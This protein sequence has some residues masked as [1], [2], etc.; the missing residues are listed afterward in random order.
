M[1]NELCSCTIQ[2][3]TLGLSNKEQ[4]VLLIKV[5]N[6]KKWNFVKGVKNRPRA[7][8][9]IPNVFHQF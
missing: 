1:E 2:T 4:N 3:L 8:N 5:D 6:E 7:P 9:E